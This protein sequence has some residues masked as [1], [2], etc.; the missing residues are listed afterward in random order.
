MADKDKMARTVSIPVELPEG[1]FLATMG[2]CADV[3]DAHS[4]WARENRSWS[5]R[6]AHRSLYAKLRLEFPELPSAMVQ[7]MRDCALEAAKA[8]KLKATP[9][10]KRI[11][12]IRYDRRTMTLR[13]RQLTL[14]C[15]GGRVRVALDV[16]DHFKGVFDNHDVWTHKG[17]TVT[18]DRDGRFWVRLVYEADMPPKAVGRI[19]GVDLGVRNIAAT[20]DGDVVSNSMVRAAQRRYLHNRRTLQAKGTPS[21]RRRLKA[22][23]GREKRFSR[24]VNHVV[25]KWLANRPGV[26]EIAMEKGLAGT[27]R[28]RRGKRL[29]KAISSWSHGQLREFTI[30]K[31]EALGKSVFLV[32]ARYT[33]QRCP[34]CRRA[35]KANR[36]KSRFRCAKCGF[37]GHADVVAAVNIWDNLLN[38]RLRAA[39]ATGGA[40]GGQAAVN[41]PTMQVGGVPARF[42]NV[43]MISRLR[44]DATGGQAAVN[45]PNATGRKGSVASH[46]PCASGS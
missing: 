19:L 31:A 24:D 30:Y 23:S 9:R 14:S 20:S 22:M 29:N 26:S 34:R 11:S 27:R 1:R 42:H 6:R 16:P 13:G 33:S 4:E 41:Q 45:Q 46:W 28:K 7:S 2:M 35:A 10:K 37:S 5:K 38:S 18:R 40:I 43:L 32:D 21:A 3:F 36:A 25:S 44:G 15:V 8:V 39:G 17:G 12:G